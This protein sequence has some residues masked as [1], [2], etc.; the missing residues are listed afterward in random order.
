[1]R[2]FRVLEVCLPLAASL[3][4][5]GVLGELWWARI[6]Y[7]FDLEWMEGGML[8]HAWRLQHHLPLYVEPNP[9]FV[10]FIYPPGY[11][12]LLAALSKIFGLTP[13]L[14]RWVSVISIVAASA[15]LVFAVRGEG[16]RWPVA[17]GT[18]A[19]F[20]GTYPQAGAFFDLIRPDSLSVALLGWSIAIGLR[21]ERGAEIASGLLLAAAFLCKHNAALFGFPMV[22]GLAMRGWR[23]A[24]RFTLAS[25][26]PA[27]AVTALLQ[28]RS[29]GLFL[30]YLL[31]VP[32]AHEMI[33]ARARDHTPRELGTALPF[34]IGLAGVATLLTAVRRQCN[35]PSWLAAALPVWLG[36]GVAWAGTY[37]PPA[38]NSGVLNVP[39][40]IAYWGLTVGLIA[41]GVRIVG[42][43]LD[44]RRG[45]PGDPLSPSAVHGLA[46]AGTAVIGAMLMRAH[47][48]GFVNVHIP[49]FW[50]IS[51]AL[52]ITLTRWRAASDALVVRAVVLLGLSGQLLWA[53]SRIDREQLRPTRADAEIGWA[54]VRAAR[55]IE[56]PVLSPFGSWIP[57]YAGRPPSIHAMAVWDC[58]HEGGPLLDEL[59]SIATALRQHEW[60]LV[61]GGTHPFLGKL[62]DHYVPIEVIVEPSDP[63]FWPNTG[64]MGRPWRL[65]VPRPGYE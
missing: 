45:L 65:M 47:D 36:I 3:L 39:S 31:E 8:A 38:P 57:V 25:V 10:P 16:G 5:L 62:T 26:L 9:D 27:L 43:A 44:R 4:L 51:L 13:A 37:Y 6:P 32:S 58:D 18:A 59:S 21:R 64:F 41:P 23:G 61:F 19:V 20:L 63:L 53:T 40:A 17:L 7:P 2:A 30:T 54:F 42:T 34:A 50:T 49:M 56:G 14:G 28:W 24:L 11:S 15:A 52:G 22:I 29:S 33:W 60:V 55:G 1:M 48:G 12:A 46:L 35:V